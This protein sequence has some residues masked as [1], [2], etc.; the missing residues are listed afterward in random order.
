MRRNARPGQSMH[1]RY[2][3][4]AAVGA[5]SRP[6]LRAPYE[7]RQGEKPPGLFKTLM[8]EGRKK[9]TKQNNPQVTANPAPGLWRPSPALQRPGWFR[10]VPVARRGEMPLVRAIAGYPRGYAL[11]L[12]AQRPGGAA[13]ERAQVRTDLQRLQQTVGAQQRQLAAWNQ[14]AAY[15]TRMNAAEQAARA[16]AR[17]TANASGPKASKTKKMMVEIFGEEPRS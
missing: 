16:N 11:S 13:P 4:F 7:N 17:A 15:E 9:K 1:G 3:M 10:G 12:T 6:N 5:G 2:M 14:W 8:G